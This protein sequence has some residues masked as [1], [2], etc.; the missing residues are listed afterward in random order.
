MLNKGRSF[1][2]KDGVSTEHQSLRSINGSNINTPSSSGFVLPMVIAGGLILMI[3][4]IILSM[5]SFS[6]LRG[7]IR[8][9]QGSQAEEIA[10]TGANM[11]IQ[12]LN[13]N[14]PYLLVV[15]CEVTN[16][17]ASEQMEPPKCEEGWES[18]ELNQINSIGKCSQ[19]EDLP[20]DI[21]LFREL[22]Y[23]PDG[24]GYYRLRSYEFLGDSVQGG[25]AII[26]VQGQLR[27]GAADNEKITASAILEKEI[28][29]IPK[30]C[31]LAPFESCN[32]S[33]DW[34][35][36]LATQ[37]LNL[38]KGDI[39]DEVR[40]ANISGANVHCSSCDLPPTE[41]CV[42]GWTGPVG[43]KR[44]VIQVLPSN[45]ERDCKNGVD[46][47]EDD[48][49]VIDGERTNGK[50]DIPPATTWKQEW[51]NLEPY[52]I[53]Y[54]NFNPG[55]G[56]YAPSITHS[57]RQGQHPS[58]PFCYTEIINDK[59]ITHCRIKNISSSIP[60]DINIKP[61]N[62]D[63]RFYIEG[64]SINL[65]NVTF[66]TPESTEFG[67]FT[68]FGGAST[69][70]SAH[71]KYKD[72]QPGGKSFNWSAGGE[73]NAF[74]YMPYFNVNFSAGNCDTTPQIIRGA[75]IT[76]GWNASGDCVQI[77]VPSDAGK[78]ICETYD[79]CSTVLSDSSEDMEY[80]A[81]GTKRWNFVQMGP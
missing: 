59:K 43:G 24:K 62:G 30:C 71:E 37:F 73:I 27:N 65:S 21:D 41:K 70:E 51:G 9:N 1:R 35:Y 36:G 66:I 49:G 14:Y 58:L 23:Q 12:E 68:I 7:A 38:D 19:R 16:N 20:D 46:L 60:L 32:S 33:S 44:E 50:L 45:R 80:V 52:T 10:E 8:Q 48:V 76:Y 75:A 28:T 15:D 3:G 40:D 17:A 22:F 63:I 26:Q 39:I 29:I 57:D 55:R 56:Y 2:F 69:W 25:T 4:A 61:E 5:R 79:V 54:D 47:T 53:G 31:D 11:I 34:K 77:Q 64:I 13:Q 74:L 6:G 42:G 18:Y 67:Q 78:I 81:V 72:L